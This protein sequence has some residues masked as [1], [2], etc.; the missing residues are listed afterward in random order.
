MCVTFLDKRVNQREGHWLN[1]RLSLRF[2]GLGLLTVAR[3]DLHGNGREH[4]RLT[5]FFNEHL[6]RHVHFLQLRIQKRL[7]ASL[8]R[9]T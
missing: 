4:E 3:F 7:F 6:Q 2:S 9:L 8:P 1:L 5:Q